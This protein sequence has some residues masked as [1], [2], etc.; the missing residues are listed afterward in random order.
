MH[1]IEGEIHVYTFKAGVLSRVAHDLKLNLERF[2]VGFEGE[3]LSAWFDTNSLQVDGAVQRGAL[4]PDLL[5]P[6]QRDEIERT[7]RAEVLK[8]DAYPQARFDGR[9]TESAGRYQVSG[10]LELVG[11]RRP[12][13]F[14]AARQERQVRA[15]LE[16][17]PSQ[18]G[19]R[20]YTA[21]FSTLR[22]ADRV[23]VV[24]RLELPAE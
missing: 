15:E 21:L 8:S 11:R 16:L 14:E 2:Q 4:A 7:I 20:P 9:V 18:W 24:L 3:E 5:S 12:L 6:A 1:G 22:V 19:I 10:E 23:R 13:Q 17:V